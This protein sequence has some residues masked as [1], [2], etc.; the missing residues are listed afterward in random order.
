MELHLIECL[1]NFMRSLKFCN[2]NLFH[3]EFGYMQQVKVL[4]L[5][6][7]IFFNIYNIG[8]GTALHST[9]PLILVVIKH[10]KI[11]LFN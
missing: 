2:L 5:V 4:V 9:S 10:V 7:G 6:P 11:H 8:N 3:F 1:I